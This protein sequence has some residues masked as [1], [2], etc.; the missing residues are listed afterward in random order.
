MPLNSVCTSCQSF[1]FI[2]YDMLLLSDLHLFFHGCFF[3][4]GL[5][6]IG[7]PS[8]AEEL[9]TEE[10]SGNVLHCKCSCIYLS[11]MCCGMAYMR[12]CSNRVECFC[13]CYWLFACYVMLLVFARLVPLHNITQHDMAQHGMQVD[14][15]ASKG[16]KV[17]YVVHE[18]LKNFMFPISTY[19]PLSSSSEQAGGGSST[20][21]SLFNSLFQ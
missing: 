21:Q 9:Q 17:R 8:R 19:S 7:R 14:R 12:Q 20:S 4:R 13:L 5:H 3:W 18:K 11:W 15:R 2:F 16:R 10:V 1:S 6:A